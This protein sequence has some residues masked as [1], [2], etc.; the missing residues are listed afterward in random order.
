MIT[1]YSKD[2]LYNDMNDM[3]PSVVNDYRRYR[4]DT[5]GDPETE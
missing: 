1:S 3:I 4:K 2:Y 5:Q